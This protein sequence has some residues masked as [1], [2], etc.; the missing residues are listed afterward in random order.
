M[1]LKILDPRLHDFPLSYATEGSAALDLRACIDGP[2]ELEPGE[3]CYISSGIALN[4]Q[5]PNIAAIVLPRSGLGSREGIVISNTIGLIDSDYQGVIGLT[6]MN[7][8]R[9]ASV[10]I[11]PMMRVCQMMFVP[12]I[13][14]KFTIVSEFSQKTERGEGGFGHSGVA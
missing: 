1:E 6:I 8:N 5:D 9:M 4:M 7:R 2:I 12:V 13:H 10:F 14:P 3:T 11:E